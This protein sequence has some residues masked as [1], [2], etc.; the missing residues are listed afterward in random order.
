MPQIV[1]SDEQASVVAA[2]LEP[3]SVRDA[4]GNF[5]GTIPPLWTRE[6]IEKAK[7][8][9]ASD[10][11]RHTTAQVLAYLRSLARNDSLYH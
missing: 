2:A 6:D 9:L 4:R 7:K 10:Q 11:P 8:A 5:L 1:L 3:V